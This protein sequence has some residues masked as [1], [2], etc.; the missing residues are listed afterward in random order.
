MQEDLRLLILII[1]FVGV[2]FLIADGMR[3]RFK[4]RRTQKFDQRV[5]ENTAKQSKIQLGEDPLFDEPLESLGLRDRGLYERE[6][7]TAEPS[8][9]DEVKEDVII[10]AIKPRMQ[11]GFSGR[12]LEAVLKSHHY[13]FGEKKIFHAHV[14]NNTSNEILFSI[15]QS[16]EPGCFDLESIKQE[17]IQ[18]LV[19][20]MQLPV[21]RDNNPLSVF[22]SMLKSA[23]Q[24]AAALNGELCDNRH[25]QLSA[26]AIAQVK[27]KIQNASQV[28]LSSKVD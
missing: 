23:R 7:K 26:K 21:A 14:D 1:G 11:D 10:F 25:R 9:Q 19:I 5:F 3:K 18:G 17:R 24:L 27:T 6:A 28:E 15:A 20:F 13:F 12:T 16:T 22:E 8:G 4:K 2:A